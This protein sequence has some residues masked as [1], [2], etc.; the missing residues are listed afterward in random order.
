VAGEIISIYGT[1]FGATNPPTPANTLL[2]DANPLAKAVTV[3]IGGVNA[4]VAWA[5]ITAPG[6]VQVNVQIPAG[7]APGNQPVMANLAGFQTLPGVF[8]PIGK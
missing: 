2:T 6:L 7:L 1:G 3:T 4:T 5:G 8:L